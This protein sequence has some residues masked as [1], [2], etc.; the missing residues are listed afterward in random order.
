[1]N[2]AFD[3]SG[4]VI[5]LTGATGGIG[6]AIVKE[7]AQSGTRLVLVSRNEEK[8]HKLADEAGGDSLCL[9]CDI[10]DLDAAQKVADTIGEKYGRVDALLNCAGCNTRKP[11]LEMLPED[12]DRVM[13]LNVRACYFFSQMIGKIMARQNYGKIVN[14]AS[15]NTY[16]SLSTVSVY[17]ASKGA[18]GQLTKAMAV[19]LA[20]YNIQ[21]N[22][23]APGFIKTQFYE[24]LWGNPE[25]NAWIEERTLCKRF[26]VPEDLTGTVHFLCSEASDFITGQIIPVDGGFL[27]GQDTLFG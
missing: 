10:T 15:L 19:D 20:K 1:M 9:S 24:L 17:A 25:K 27:A 5:V 6:S 3:I 7:M 23:I 13:G 21:V 22:A 26:G 12:Y 18:V 16:I 11:F 4:K 14:F 8:M 2:K